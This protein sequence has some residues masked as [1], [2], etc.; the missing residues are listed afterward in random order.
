[1][2]IDESMKKTEVRQT[3][4]LKKQKKYITVVLVGDSDKEIFCICIITLKL[5]H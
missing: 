2:F 3:P 4:Y 1:M 5:L